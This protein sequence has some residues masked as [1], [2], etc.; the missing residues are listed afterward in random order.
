MQRQDATSGS[1]EEFVMKFNIDMR[2]T[3]RLPSRLAVGLALSAFLALGTFA[4]PA[5][6]QP[7]GYHENHGGENHGG[8]GHYNNQ[9]GWN[10]HQQRWN[11]G[12]GYYPA[13][14]VVVYGAPAYI[15]PPVIYSPGIVVGVPGVGININ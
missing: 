5:S 6:A 10:N 14:P 2:S 11:G 4:A 1:S 7:N 13:P 9:Q 15:A 8:G 3:S 12:G